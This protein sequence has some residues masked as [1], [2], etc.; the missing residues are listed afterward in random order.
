MQVGVSALISAQQ[1]RRFG[2]RKRIRNFRRVERRRELNRM[3]RERERANG[4]D[5]PTSKFF[6]VEESEDER[7]PIGELS[8]STSATDKK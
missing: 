1:E 6:N 3:E 7:N 2:R 4:R 8:T 5:R